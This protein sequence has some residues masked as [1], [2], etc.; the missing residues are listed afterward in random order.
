MENIKYKLFSIDLDGTILSRV[1]RKI[2]KNNCK[3][4]QKYMNYGGIPIL[5][6]GRSPWMMTRIVKKINSYGNKKIKY[7]SCWNGALIKDLSTNL[8]S[9]SFLNNKYAWMIL[10]ILH[11]SKK[12]IAWFYLAKN[13]SFK[14]IKIYPRFSITRL[15]KS[16][17]KFLTINENDDLTSTKIIIYGDKNNVTTIYDKMINASFSKFINIIRSNDKVIEIMPLGVD[18]GFAIR[19]IALKLNIPIHKVITIGDS[20]NDL[21]AFKN[22]GFAICVKHRKNNKLSQY[23]NVTMKYKKNILEKALNQFIIQDINHKV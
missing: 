14:Y 21:A 17:G 11:Q 1:F 8:Y 3:A 23:A 12:V 10:N 18:K 2:S 22:S 5:N 15:I 7:I 20:F 4:I 19:Q 16:L 9:A 13:P 6:S